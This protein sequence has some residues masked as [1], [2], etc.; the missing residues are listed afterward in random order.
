LERHANETRHSC[1]PQGNLQNR[2]EG[3][4]KTLNTHI[5]D[6]KKRPN[7]IR[8]LSIKAPPEV[9]GRA[10][11][12]QRNTTSRI[13]QKTSEPTFAR[14]CKN[15]PHKRAETTPQQT[16]GQNKTLFFIYHA[17]R[18]ERA[19]NSQFPR[20][21]SREKL[22]CTICERFC[23]AEHCIGSKETTL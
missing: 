20:K 9:R 15:L 11:R 16:Y 13:N 2:K 8:N 7:F 12:T 17:N 5:I 1:N 21:K 19:L 23:K 6:Q 18:S 3:I 22:A 10:A 4:S 14:H